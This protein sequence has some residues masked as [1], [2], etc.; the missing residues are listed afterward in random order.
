[1]TS[2]ITTG[3]RPGRAHPNSGPPVLLT[4]LLA[5]VIGVA[6]PLACKIVL[7][8]RRRL[9]QQLGHALVPTIQPIATG[10]ELYRKRPSFPCVP[11]QC[12]QQLLGFGLASVQ[13]GRPQQPVRLWSVGRGW[14][15][16][17]ADVLCWLVFLNNQRM[18]PR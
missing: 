18:R 5:S 6:Q 15:G 4:G 7:L 11:A 14:V 12:V 1:M 8:P 9:E 17:P 16:E 2:S 3:L 13:L 10:Q